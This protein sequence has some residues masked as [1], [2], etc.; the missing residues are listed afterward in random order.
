ME[1]MDEMD[2]MDGM[3]GTDEGWGCWWRLPEAPF[4]L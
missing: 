4:I 3:D 2:E 1:K